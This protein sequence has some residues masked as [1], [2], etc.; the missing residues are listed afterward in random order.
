MQA[1]HLCGRLPACLF[2][3]ISSFHRKHSWCY[4]YLYCHHREQMLRRKAMKV[5]ESKHVCACVCMQGKD[6]WLF[7]NRNT[8]KDIQVMSIGFQLLYFYITNRVNM[9]ASSEGVSD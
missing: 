4:Q 5:V 7:S 6:A 9:C 1:R 3:Y 8:Q 2:F